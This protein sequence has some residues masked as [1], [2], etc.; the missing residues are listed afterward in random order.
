[1]QELDQHGQQ[2]DDRVTQQQKMID[3]LKRIVEEQQKQIDEL[4]N[5]K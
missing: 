5:K 2:T 1:V 3:E 4:L